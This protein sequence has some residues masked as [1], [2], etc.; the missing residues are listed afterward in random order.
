MIRNVYFQLNLYT[1]KILV[2]LLAQ[3]HNTKYREHVCLPVKKILPVA[4]LRPQTT[5]I[6]KREIGDVANPGERRIPPPPPLRPLANDGA[7]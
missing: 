1:Y 5:P 6:D 3:S 4:K 2:V 7:V